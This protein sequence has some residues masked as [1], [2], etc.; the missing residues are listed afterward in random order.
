MTATAPPRREAPG[1]SDIDH[2]RRPLARRFTYRYVAAMVLFVVLALLTKV[3][4]DSSSNRVSDL[5]KQS[6]ALS[7]QT[8]RLDQV[9]D[10]AG[11]VALQA[12]E[13]QQFQY[14]TWSAQLRQQAQDLRDVEDALAG[15]RPDADIPTT[16]LSP[17]LA[18]VHTG[19]DRLQALVGE[20]ADNAQAIAVPP[21]ARLADQGDATGLFGA[22]T[23][24]QDATRTALD[25]A[26]ALYA[27]A[28][29]DE[30]TQ[31]RT[32]TEVLLGISAVVVLAVVV[33]IFRP[34]AR[35]IH[36]E[37]SQLERAERMQ[38]ESNERQTFRSD[39]VEALEVTD[40]ER[41]VL[42]AVGRAFT[43]V[44]PGRPAELLLADSSYSHLRATQ[45]NPG[46]DGPSCPVDS[47]MGCAAVRR[48]EAVVYE[49]STILSVCPK[50]P[51]HQDAPCSAV[52][53]PVMFMGKAL[54]VVH[55]TGPDGEAPTTTEVERLSVVASETGHRL[56]LM[57]SSHASELAAST[58]GLTGLLNRRSLEGRVR[59]MMLD[60]EPFSVAMADLD[61]FKVLNDR[62]GHESGDRALRT[63][64][65]VLKA[66]LRPDDVVARYGGEE[67]VV[68]L[69]NTP[70]P[71]A[72]KA[73]QRVQSALSDELTHNGGVRFT[74]SW[75]L[76]DRSAGRA[77]DEIV[78]V[79]DAAMYDAKRSGRDCIMVDG[80]A[81]RRSGLPRAARPVVARRKGELTVEEAGTAPDVLRR[82][83]RVGI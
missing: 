70:L 4:I 61:R 63:F 22:I 72:L 65:S 18:S 30:V 5:T 79:A 39:L 21:G 55:T 62:H 59:T 19:P 77:F 8:R 78:A 82:G 36:L 57:R 2:A 41:E 48:G 9:V 24:N 15:S 27:T 29:Q 80:I 76:T 44:V 83:P 10:L 68:I 35:S 6:A 3:S 53:V 75:G 47:P 7:G 42:A 11:K 40:S 66:C 58:D 14:E 50:L 43:R 38:R 54:G 67:F 52:C 33:G 56:G 17:E 32:T 64:A 73:L 20:I 28:T 31:Q 37:T 12:D 46:I 69:P 1:A 13:S 81:A 16:A 45:T 71:D 74:A 25:K 23:R 49:S 26:L 34:M 51:E 60:D